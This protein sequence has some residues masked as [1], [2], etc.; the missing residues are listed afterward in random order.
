[1]NVD[2]EKIARVGYKTLRLFVNWAAF[3]GMEKSLM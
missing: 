1:M 2:V 3:M